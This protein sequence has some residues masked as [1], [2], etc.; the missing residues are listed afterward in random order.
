MKEIVKAIGVYLVWMVGFL[1]V[2]ALAWNFGGIFY[3]SQT[4]L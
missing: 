4:A 1:I 3:S 2:V